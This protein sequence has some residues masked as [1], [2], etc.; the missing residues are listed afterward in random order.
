MEEMQ[1]FRDSL[2]P[3]HSCSHTER[4]RVDARG[5]WCLINCHF[6]VFDKLSLQILNN[7]RR[8]G[9]SFY[10]SPA[11]ISFASQQV[12]LNMDVHVNI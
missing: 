4:K 5:G 6:V 9:S 12:E 10:E 8:L 3:K 7:N 1:C 11:A 2:C